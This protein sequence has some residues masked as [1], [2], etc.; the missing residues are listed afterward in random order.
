MGI[1]RVAL[2]DLSFRII[3]SIPFFSSSRYFVISVPSRNFRI[4]LFGLVM[5]DHFV[6]LVDRLITESTLEAAIES[7]IRSMQATASC[8]LELLEVEEKSCQNADYEDISVPRK[9]VECRIC[10]DEDVD[11]NMETPC[12][13]CGS[14]KYAHRRCVQKW[15]NEKGNTT[16]EICHQQFKPGY[17]APP[18][19]FHLGRIP[20]NLRG[21]RDISRRDMRVVVTEHNL[22]TSPDYDDE[23]SAFSQRNL[24]CCRSIAILLLF[25]RVSG[26]V[27]PIYVLVKSL[28]VLQ[29]R[30]EQ[31]QQQQQHQQMQEI[32]L[33]DEDP[34]EEDR[35]ALQLESHKLIRSD[36]MKFLEYTP[37]ERIDDFL[38]HL[39]LGECTIKGSLEAYSCK[40][41]GSDKKLS[42]SLE[43]EILDYLGKS[44]DTDS[45]SPPEYLLSRSSRK[46]L[47]YL[48]L[49]LSH[50]YPDYDFSAMKAHQF[51]TKETWGTFKQ[52]FDIH[53][54]GASKE[55]R[56]DGGDT[57]LLEVIYRALDEVVNLS[58]CEIYSYDPDSDVN[59]FLERGAIWSFSFFF[60]NKKLKRVVSFCCCCVS[61]DS[62][63]EIFDDMDM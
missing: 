23:N 56:E 53:M 54:M 25:L 12:S 36:I 8:D 27:L 35:L 45:S 38:N 46:T 17:T 51:F 63:G 42:F 24:I 7:R 21:N 2:L 55:W 57:S 29:Q 50:M 37:L 30:R 32:P 33:S 52:M 39:N 3:P 48:I 47:I 58:E 10:Q 60:Y 31:Q 16:C 22:A 18:P 34:D 41:A 62:D 1:S 6:V 19:L 5:G 49:T 11:S 61:D 26:I 44:S 9:M 14:L 43:N 59:P 40:H 28:T 4:R 15:C 13:C 20:I